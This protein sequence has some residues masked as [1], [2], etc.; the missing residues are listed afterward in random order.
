MSTS[1][2]QTLASKYHSP[3]GSHGSLKKYLTPDLEHKKNKL[4]LRTL[5][6]SESKE[7]L[8]DE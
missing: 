8:N 4:I 2:T 6:V 3:Q 7:M 1:S 5:T